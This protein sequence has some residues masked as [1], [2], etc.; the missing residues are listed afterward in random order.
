VITGRFVIKGQA[1]ILK[2]TRGLDCLAYLLRHSARDV[3]VSELL[4]TPIDLLAPAL[5][6]SLREA[7]G[8][9][10]PVGLQ[11]AGFL[12]GLS[13]YNISSFGF[14]TRTVPQV[15]HWRGRLWASLRR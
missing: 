8:D 3:H 6:G 9:A 15:F 14:E 10:V 1:A 12:F 5:L 13:P 11:N 4:A 7:R 2:A